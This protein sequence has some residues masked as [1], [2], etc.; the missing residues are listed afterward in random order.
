MK[1]L[2]YLTE[3]HNSFDKPGIMLA[4]DGVLSKDIVSAFLSRLREDI[5]DV[6]VP[7]REKK[8]F[9]S[10]VVECIQNLSKHG[11]VSES[12]DDRFLILV[13]RESNEFRVS[14]GNIIKNNKRNRITELINNVNDKNPEELQSLYVNGITNN[15]LSEEGEAKLGLID[16]ARKSSEKLRYQFNPIDDQSSFF[17][18][19][20]Q[21]NVV[22]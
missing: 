21:I 17:I 15:R 18:F 11:K 4:Y 19:Q 8:R 22:L 13:E 6:E 14:T 7:K 2:N 16:I 5:E 9:F 12:N 20:S 1:N 10:V 3:F